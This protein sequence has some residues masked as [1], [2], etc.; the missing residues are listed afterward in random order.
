MQRHR[1]GGDHHAPL[2][3]QVYPHPQPADPQ[4]AAD[5]GVLG[6]VAAD[7]IHEQ[8]GPEPPRRQLGAGQP[9]QAGQGLRGQQRQGH[10]VK[11]SAV[12]LDHSDAGPEFGRERGVGHVEFAAGGR[13]YQR[14]S[15]VG[16]GPFGIKGPVARHLGPFPYGQPGEA[17]A[18]LPVPDER[19]PAITRYAVP[20]DLGAVQLLGRHGFDWIPPQRDDATGHGHERLR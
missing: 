9:A 14:R 15:G 18:H 5:P 20:R 17:A 13:A 19:P 1:V 6:E 12:L 11:D 3:T 2:V 4:H 10:R 16:P 8:V 7:R